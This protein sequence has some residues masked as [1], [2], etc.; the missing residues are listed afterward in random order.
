[1]PHFLFSEGKCCFDRPF[2]L[3]TGLMRPKTILACAGWMTIR[4]IKKGGGKKRRKTKPLPEE[5][6]WSF[7]ERLA[8]RSQMPANFLR[9]RHGTVDSV[10]FMTNFLLTGKVHATQYKSKR[11]PEANV[12]LFQIWSEWSQAHFQVCWLREKTKHKGK[13]FNLWPCSPAVGLSMPAPKRSG[14]RKRLRAI[15]R[16]TSLTVIEK[17]YLLISVFIVY[18]VSKSVVKIGSSVEAGKHVGVALPHYLIC[19]LKNKHNNR[20]TFS[21]SNFENKTLPWKSGCCV[22]FGELNSL[23]LV[24]FAVYS[25]SCQNI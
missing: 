19:C 13:G 14:E 1:M 18:F 9:W 21:T 24:F 22:N 8:H 25:S 15:N 10:T 20:E 23:M 17:C 2:C 11:Q 5:T 16:Y 12:H 3:T 7:I 6:V 4:L